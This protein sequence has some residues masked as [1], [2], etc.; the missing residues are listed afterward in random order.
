MSEV[1]VTGLADL[2]RALDTLPA[3]IERNILRGALRAGAKVTLARAKDV[4]PA[5]KFGPHAGALRAGLSI[6][7]S[8]RGGTVK[9]TV[10]TGGKAFY[11]RFVEYGTKAHWIKPKHHRSLFFAGIA[12]KAVRHPGAKAN[13]FM[14][15]ALNST[16]HAAVVAF[17]EYIRARLI[18]KHGIDIP[19]ESN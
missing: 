7:T 4:A 17:A 1:H 10:S 5:E 2:Q 14:L 15:V 6:K 18:K 16:A 3:K 12:R 9:A 19:S 11:A 8:S 13:P